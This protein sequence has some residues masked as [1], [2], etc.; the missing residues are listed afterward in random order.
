MDW[1]REQDIALSLGIFS[2]ACFLVSLFVIPV[3]IARIPADYFTHRR[4]TPPDARHPALRITILVAKNAVG[5]LLVLAGITMLVLPGQGILT[6]LI[7]LL[8]MNFPGKYA[9]ERR[10]ASSP[11]VLRGLNWIRRKAGAEPLRLQTRV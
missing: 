6:V 8:L 3:L 1:L 2:I 7:G 9:L 10:I 4:R 11:A 5:V